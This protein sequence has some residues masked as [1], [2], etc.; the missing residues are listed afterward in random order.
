MKKDN[1]ILIFGAIAIGLYYYMQKNKTVNPGT[2]TTGPTTNAKRASIIAWWETNEPAGESVTNPGFEDVINNISPAE[3]N[4]IYSYIF[5]YFSKG[6][7][8]PDTL[9]AQVDQIKSYYGIFQ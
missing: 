3:I 1:S 2:T 8:V 6:K 4:T 7:T 5:D 9:S